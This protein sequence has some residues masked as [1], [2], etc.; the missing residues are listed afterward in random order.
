MKKSGLFSDAKL[1]A[2]IKLQNFNNIIC[3]LMAVVIMVVILS[4]TAFNNDIVFRISSITG[5]ATG[6]TWFVVNQV[7]Q[8]KELDKLVDKI[9]NKGERA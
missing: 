9:I 5:T 8:I 7:C 1:N 3:W 2:E 4:V 6:I